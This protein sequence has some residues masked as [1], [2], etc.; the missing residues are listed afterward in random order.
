M[1]RIENFYF[2]DDEDAGEKIFNQFAAQ[3]SHYF[4]GD[5][6]ATEEENKL[7]YT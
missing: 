6:N 3:H 4:H 2:S 5:V 1:R 7:E